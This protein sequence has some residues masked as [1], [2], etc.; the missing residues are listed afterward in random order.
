MGILQLI[1]D[2]INGFPAHNVVSYRSMHSAFFIYWQWMNTFNQENRTLSYLQS[3]KNYTTIYGHFF[4]QWF[5]FHVNS[6]FIFWSL[7]FPCSQLAC[8]PC[9]MWRGKLPWTIL[10][11]WRTWA[12]RQCR[13]QPRKKRSGIFMLV[14]RWP[15][16]PV[17]SSELA[18]FLKRGDFWNLQ[19]TKQL[20]QVNRSGSPA[21]EWSSHVVHVCLKLVG[22]QPHSNSLF[23]LF[24]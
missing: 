1:F 11:T 7:Y 14:W 23:K 18:L 12:I 16:V 24:T 21:I 19:S 2:L 17:C 4:M 20:E 13:S 10:Q 3:S 6:Y 9:W 8:L 22:I 15:S 5:L